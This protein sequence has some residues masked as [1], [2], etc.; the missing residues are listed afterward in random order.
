MILY[1][2]NKNLYY[3]YFS[4]KRNSFSSGPAPFL[5]QL[6]RPK[7]LLCPARKVIEVTKANSGELPPAATSP[8][9]TKTPARP[10]RAGAP[11]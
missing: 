3:S 2:L 1:E 10:T 8:A 4:E 11:T 5:L 6:G 7:Q 9:A